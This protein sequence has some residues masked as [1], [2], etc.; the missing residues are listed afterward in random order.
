MQIADLKKELQ[1]KTSKLDE[2]KRMYEKLV[3]DTERVLTD[4]AR[5]KELDI[6]QP[7]WLPDTISTKG[8]FDVFMKNKV[9]EWCDV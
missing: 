5:R 6:K 9:I 8:L 4:E 2:L 1:Q 7:G 3:K